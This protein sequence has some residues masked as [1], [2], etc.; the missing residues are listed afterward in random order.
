MYRSCKI[1]KGDKSFILRLESV[2]QKN[3]LSDELREHITGELI[4][5]RKRNLPD[6]EYVTIRELLQFGINYDD[7]RFEQTY[8][9]LM[10][11]RLDHGY[12]YPPPILGHFPYGEHL[13]K[14]IPVDTREP[15]NPDDHHIDVDDIKSLMPKTKELEDS[16]LKWLKPETLNEIELLWK[17]FLKKQNDYVKKET[18][19]HGKIT[20][21]LITKPN[22]KHLLLS[23]YTGLKSPIPETIIRPLKAKY[24]ASREKEGFFS[25]IVR[26]MAK[27]EGHK[28]VV[29]L[30]DEVLY[31]EIRNIMRFT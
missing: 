5:L 16:L 19:N 17:A 4:E 2:L 31:Q 23:A 24:T 22:L 25:D 21:E 7:I 14:A 1:V 26:Q 10:L 6:K 9:E 12:W 8:G 15:I 29:T 20:K 27:K 28:D 18:R 13:Y 30:R 3:D 11:Y